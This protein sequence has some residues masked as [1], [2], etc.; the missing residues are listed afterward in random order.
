MAEKRAAINETI[1]KEQ[2]KRDI[3]VQNA[4]EALTVKLEKEARKEK[5]RALAEQRKQ[6]KVCH[7][8]GILERFKVDNENN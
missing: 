7:T 8:K 2:K 1:E 5:E 3:F 4:L 6:L